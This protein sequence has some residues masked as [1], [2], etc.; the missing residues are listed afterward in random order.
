MLLATFGLSLLPLTAFAQLKASADVVKAKVSASK[1]DADGNQ[2]IT[3]TL[4]IDKG[5]HLYANPVK[6]EN[7]EE[8]ATEVSVAGKVKP[9]SVKTAYPKGQIQKDKDVGDM[10]IYTGTVVIKVNVKRAKGDKAPLALTVRINACNEKK[11]LE[12][13]KVKLEVS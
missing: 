3:V 13:S 10:S 9:I 12:Q 5:W 8:N 1:V 4:T 2:V 11:C 7:F 6:N